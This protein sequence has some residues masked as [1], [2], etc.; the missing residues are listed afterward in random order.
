MGNVLLG[1]EDF[2]FKLSAVGPRARLETIAGE[3][4]AGEFFAVVDKFEM[5]F[6]DGTE[7][8]IYLEGLERLLGLGD[9]PECGFYLAPDFDTEPS[10]LFNSLWAGE[11]EH[12]EMLAKHFES[13]GPTSIEV[14]SNVMYRFYQDD[15]EAMLAYI[16]GQLPDEAALTMEEIATFDVG[17]LQRFTPGKDEPQRADGTGVAMYFHETIPEDGHPFFG[18]CILV[19]AVVNDL[20]EMDVEEDPLHYKVLWPKEAKYDEAYVHDDEDDEDEEDE[21]DE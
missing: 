8:T 5:T 10:F 3:A 9:D 14:Y 20:E 1:T 17:T 4:G 18:L 11:K 6:K 21:E 7:E 19:H 2:S 13:R 12:C 15:W 16:N